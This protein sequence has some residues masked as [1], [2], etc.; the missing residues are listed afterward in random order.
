MYNWKLAYCENNQCK[1]LDVRLS[2]DV[3]KYGLSVIDAEVPGNFEFDMMR[4]GLIPDLYYSDNTLIAQRLENLH[5]WYFTELDVTETDC[6]LRFEG[7][8][9]VCDIYV[10]GEYVASHDNMF[11]AFDVAPEFKIGKNE[12]LVHIKPAALEARRKELPPS[13]TGMRYNFPSLS[14]RKAAHSF[15]W[16]IMPRIVSGGIY[17]PVTLLKK[18]KNYIRSLYATTEVLGGGDGTVLGF[19]YSLDVEGDFI[20]EYSVRVR[21]SC[22]G[23]SFENS[24]VAWHTDGFIRVHLFDPH[25]WW[26]KNMGEQNLYDTVFELYKNGELCDSYKLRIGVRKIELVTEEMNADGEGGEFCFYVNGKKFFAL[27]TNWV[28]LDAFHSQDLKRLPR[29]LELLDDIGCNMVR[30]WGGNVYESDEFYDFC[31]EKG[32]LVWQD[33]AMGCATYPNDPQTAKQI[34]DEAVCEIKRLR[35]HPSLALWAGDNECDIATMGWDFIY[36][37]PTL[38][39]LTRDVLKRAVS[40]WDYTRAYLP[41]SPY[42][43]EK[44]FKEKLPLPEDHIWGPRDWFKS[45]FYRNATCHFASETGYHGF[46]SVKSLR[47]FLKE[48]ER[49]FDENG[50]PTEEYTVHAA[51]PET[52][53]A[54]PYSYRIRLS[55]DQVVTLFG[56]AENKLEDFVLQSQISQAEAMKYFIERF[57]IGKWRR[58]GIIWWNLIDGWPQISDAVVDYYYGKKLA[59]DFIKRSQNPVCLM[60]DEFDGA[61]Y[62]LYAANETPNDTEVS[63]RVIDAETEKTLVSGMVTAPA[64][65]TVKVDEIVTFENERRFLLIEWDIDGKVNRNHYV[66]NIKGIDYRWYVDLLDKCNFR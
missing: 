29:A 61:A 19:H 2:E 62:S 65:S 16:D 31:D 18:R 39:I 63:Y 26:P 6:F 45:S 3:K 30:C 24:T 28:P 4:A 50:R 27:G 25:L 10:N 44:S 58:T 1:N 11:T 32:I 38:N 46:P 49:I 5:L 47:E 37:D 55:H 21:G 7:V 56:K 12:L 8:D 42:V 20:T 34:E 51:S 54:S 64:F 14:L 35:N 59:Y 17:K 52:G 22:R 40:T 41:S 13:A 53:S 9:T 48:P 23:Q 15:G 60:I 57:R 66:T 36:R 43:S 33:F